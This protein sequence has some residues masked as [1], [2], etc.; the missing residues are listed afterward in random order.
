MYFKETF[1]NVL[2]KCKRSLIIYCINTIFILVFYYL[3]IG[4]KDVIYPLFISIVFLIIYIII[5][6]ISYKEFYYKLDMAQNS[7]DYEDISNDQVF[8]T[9][10]K[11]HK[12]YNKKLYAIEQKHKEKLSFSSQWIHNMKTSSTI[13]DLACE[14]GLNKDSKD[15]VLRDIKDENEKLKSNLEQGLNFLRLDDFS[16]DYAINEVNVYDMVSNIIN[17]KKRDFIYHG[18]FPKMDLDRNLS[19]YTDLKWCRY[20]IEQ[21]IGNSIKYSSKNSNKF[22]RITAKN[23]QD[24]ISLIIA[25]KGIGIDKEDIS[26]VFEPFFTGNNG[27]RDNHSTGIGLYMVK[28]ISENLKHPVEIKSQKNIGTSVIITFLQPFTND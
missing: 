27:R 5:E 16:K 4:T 24:T 23:N 7:P 10:S 17:S 20:M 9:I 28:K 6:F 8:I 12:E 18:I 19:V 1:I 11:L 25:D 3:L 2:K 14:K 22:V 26:R 13:I 15:W 21:I